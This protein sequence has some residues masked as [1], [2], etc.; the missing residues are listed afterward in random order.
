[1]FA[2]EVTA[3]EVPDG[4]PV[5]HAKEEHAKGEEA[6]KSE[7]KDR[8]ASKDRELEHGRDRSRQV[9]QP[10]VLLLVFNDPAT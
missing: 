4:A 6:P 7:E 3:K 8:E 5:E 9:Y 1:M 2:G 10:T